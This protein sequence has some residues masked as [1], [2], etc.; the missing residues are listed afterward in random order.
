MKQQD[1]DIKDF[2]SFFPLADD[3]KGKHFCVTGATGLI[4]SVLV[5]CLLAL[6]SSIKITIPVRSKEKAVAVFGDCYDRLIV[7]PIVSLEE[8]CFSLDKSFD[9]IVHCASPTNGK[10]MQENPVDTFALAYQSTYNLLQACLRLNIQ[11]FIYLSSL[12]YYGQILDDSIPVT[13]DVQGFVDSV[14]SRSSYPFGKRAAEYLCYAFAT[15][16]GVNAK[17]A[18]L[19]QT[20][21]AGVAPND[22]RVFAQFARSVI[23]NQNIILHTTG[24]SAKPYCYTTDCISAILH[25]LI[26]GT[27]GQAYNV[28]NEDSYISIKELAK[29]LRDTFNPSISVNIDLHSDYGYAPETKLRLSTEKLKALGWKP[30]YGLKEMFERLI[31]SFS[32]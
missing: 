21:G 29:F 20:F 16:Y 4:G 1:V 5:K 28:A 15:Q 12:E 11:G 32:D 26:K 27:K 31:V 8:W 19:T 9:F 18:R 24:S 22:N 6:D 2:V 17:V 13:E 10:F 7:E 30:Q 25:I 14:S 3:V 23:N